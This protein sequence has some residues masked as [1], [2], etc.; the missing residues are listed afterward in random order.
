MKLS[1]FFA[2]LLSLYLSEIDDLG[3]DSEGVSKNALTRHIAERRAS[4]GSI[5]PILES[6]PEMGAVCFFGTKVD[7]GVAARI[8]SSDE[9]VLLLWK[10]VQSGVTFPSDCLDLVP[11]VTNTRFLVITAGLE[12]A[13]QKGVKP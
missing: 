12:Y 9:Y 7:P 3:R 2:D 4:F 13:R 11:Q 8:L 10:D 1:Q 6:N 5:I